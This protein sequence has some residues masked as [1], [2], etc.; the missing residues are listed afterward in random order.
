MLTGAALALGGAAVSLTR[1]AH[2]P[3]EETGAKL[4]AGE[5]GTSTGGVPGAPA[6]PEGVVV[7]GD[8]GRAAREVAGGDGGRAARE[9]AGAEAEA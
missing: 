1:G 4:P 2:E 5:P 6:G 8:G 9:V 3:A 7:A